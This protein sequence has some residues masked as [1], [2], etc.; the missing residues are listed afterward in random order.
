VQ[1]EPKAHRMQCLAQRDFRLSMPAS[2]AGH[3]PRAGLF[4]HD[5][6]QVRSALISETWYDLALA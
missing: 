1:A 5:V 6:G 2:D 3:H 4:V